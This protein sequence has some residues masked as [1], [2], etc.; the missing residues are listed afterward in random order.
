[1][2][3]VS[4]VENDRGTEYLKLQGDYPHKLEINISNLIRFYKDFKIESIKVSKIFTK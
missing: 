2:K 3:N 4:K 1:M